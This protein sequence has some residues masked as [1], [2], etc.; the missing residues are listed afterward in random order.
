MPASP[1]PVKVSLPGPSPLGAKSTCRHI[2]WGLVW[3]TL[4]SAAWLFR[5]R[6]C[7]VGGTVLPSPCWGGSSSASPVLFPLVSSVTMYSLGPLPIFAVA[8]PTPPLYPGALG[9]ALTRGVPGSLTLFLS[10]MGNP[11]ITSNWPSQS[12]IWFSLRVGVSCTVVIFL[13]ACTAL[14]H[15]SV[16]LSSSVEVRLTGVFG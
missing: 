15:S 5:G 13:T 11:S 7:G 12:Y 4:P 10:C 8:P 14:C 2:S 9:E 16:H 3:P 1:G 6:G